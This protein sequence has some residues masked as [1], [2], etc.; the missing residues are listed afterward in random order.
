MSILSIHAASSY[1]MKK[2]K[3]CFKRVILWI[4][5]VCWAANVLMNWQIRR[6]IDRT[7][8]YNFSFLSVALCGILPRQQK[9]STLIGGRKSE[10]AV[11]LLTFQHCVISF[12][13]D[14][15]PSIVL[16]L[17]IRLPAQ[18]HCAWDTYCPIIGK[19]SICTMLCCHDHKKLSLLIFPLDDKNN[20]V[21]KV[22]T[23][24]Q[25]CAI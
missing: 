10:V 9:K 5:S 18:G 11:Y 4:C 15:C 14:L 19:W 12:H 25:Y 17:I 7:A 3:H 22:E 13:G 1:K 16:V 2:C 21:C 24:S 20:E 8:N 6:V 23:S